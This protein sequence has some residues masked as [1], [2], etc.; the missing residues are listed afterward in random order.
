[1]L[2]EG[3]LAFPGSDTIKTGCREGLT[4]ADAGRQQREQ[5][6]ATTE[7][8]LAIYQLEAARKHL[9]KRGDAEAVRTLDAIIDRLDESRPG[10][11][12][13][14]LLTVREAA[15]LLGIRWDSILYRWARDGFVE[16][17]SADARVWFVRSSIEKLVGSPLVRD[18]VSLEAETH[19]ALAPFDF[20]DE[21]L[22]EV[23]DWWPDTDTRD[24]GE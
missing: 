4:R 13:G 2:T 23:Y 8:R 7:D 21:E 22:R 24:T 20:T 6:M 11:H 16:L 5:V 18:Q 1:L 14:D 12:P 3:A 19:A 10:H 15:G 17:K 9:Q